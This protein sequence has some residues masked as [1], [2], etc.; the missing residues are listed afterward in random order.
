MLCHC[1]ISL[2]AAEKPWQQ[3]ALK[4]KK[5]RN[6]FKSLD[7]CFEAGAPELREVSLSGE[8]SAVWIPGDHST[9][10]V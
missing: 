10:S 7:L 3:D 6:S 2:T 5:K 4:K 8:I 9:F 1:H